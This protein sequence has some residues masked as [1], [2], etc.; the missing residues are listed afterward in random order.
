MATLSGLQADI[1]A[2]T[3]HDSD[4]Q[5]TDAQLLVWINK[6]YFRLRRI[7]GDV[8]PKLYSAQ[9]TFT[10]SSGNT[11]AIVASDF[12][13]IYKLERLN[14]G[15]SYDPMVVAN[16]LD[17]EVIPD[18]A[19]AA[20]LERGATLEIYPSTAASASYRLTYTTKPTALAS[21]GDAC[22]VPEGAEEVIVQRVAARVR[23]RFEEDPSPHQA[24]AAEALAEVRSFIQR[25]YGAH[26]EGLRTERR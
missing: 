6:E 3:D 4:T 24:L 5:V 8:A 25:R 13:R 2:A 15:S 22:T 19:V 14:V 16:E 7:I 18:G 21:A 9:V 26:P 12:E 20:F 10:I 1:R 23:I 17:P 11:Y